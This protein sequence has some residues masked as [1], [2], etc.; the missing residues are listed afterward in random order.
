VP[1]TN[2]YVVKHEAARSFIAVL[3]RLNANQFRVGPHA[4]AERFQFVIASELGIPKL[5]HPSVESSE[6]I[7]A[8]LLHLIF[9]W[10]SAAHYHQILAT[11]IAAPMTTAVVSYALENAAVEQL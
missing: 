9:M 2:H 7:L 6:D 11:K 10:G 3:E 8:K 4:R 1:E 5:P